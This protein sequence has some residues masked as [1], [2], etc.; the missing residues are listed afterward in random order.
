MAVTLEFPEYSLSSNIPPHSQEGKEGA[1]EVWER[2]RLCK[3]GW[4][5]LS[6]GGHQGSRGGLGWAWSPNSGWGGQQRC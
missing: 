5:G 3:G 4:M 1:A 6:Q 2:C